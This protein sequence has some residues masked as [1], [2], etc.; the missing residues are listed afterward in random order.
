M[1]VLSINQKKWESLSEQHRAILE[2]ACGDSLQ[3]M[4]AEGEATQWK[5]MKELR[6]KHGVKL[7]R[8]PPEILRAME[9]GWAEVAAEEAA[10]NPN[11]KRVHDSF[12]KFRTDY[13]LWREYGYMQ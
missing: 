5:A 7:M 9:K 11:F 1:L 2:Q 10:K 4:I 13:A 6:D 12:V 3:D 8:W